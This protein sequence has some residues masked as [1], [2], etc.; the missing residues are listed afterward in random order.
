[1][2]TIALQLCAVI[3]NIH[4]LLAHI[5]ITCKA[6]WLKACCMLYKSIVYNFPAKWLGTDHINDHTNTN[7]VFFLLC[8]SC[9]RPCPA[10][11]HRL[12]VAGGWPAWPN[13][14]KGRL[15][16]AE[17]RP[18]LLHQRPAQFLE[19]V[20]SHVGQSAVW[21]GQVAVW[22]PLPSHLSEDPQD[23][24]EETEEPCYKER[25]CSC[26]WWISLLLM[27]TLLCV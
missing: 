23:K 4:G 13:G 10:E 19:S 3:I 16:W 7:I 21:P 25:Y 17:R 6:L 24:P 12:W 20:A 8:S 14:N 1:M 2:C 22:K 26:C 5:L 9:R 18:T 11:N 27:H 15:Q